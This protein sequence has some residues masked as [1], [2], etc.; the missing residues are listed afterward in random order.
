[1]HVTGSSP[2]VFK[3]SM[4]THQGAYYPLRGER[5]TVQVSLPTDIQRQIT[6]LHDGDVLTTEGA[7]LRVIATPGHTVDHISLL[8]EEENAVFTGDCI[9]GE[10]S[11]VSGRGG[12]WCEWQ[13]CDVAIT[14]F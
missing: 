4:E 14:H 8:L 5:N 13:C 12:Q 2:R 1:M 10:G 3:M 7:T 6:D 9:L 11:A